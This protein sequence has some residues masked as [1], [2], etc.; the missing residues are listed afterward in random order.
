M[1]GDNGEALSLGEAR[2]RV[3]EARRRR[4]RVAVDEGKRGGR[5]EVQYCGSSDEGVK[6]HTAVQ[7][8]E[9][10]KGVNGEGKGG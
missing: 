9:G 2:G 4:Q 1:K 8:G 10:E 5:N 7:I 6:L 3:E